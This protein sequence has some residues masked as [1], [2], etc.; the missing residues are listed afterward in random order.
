M[1]GEECLAWPGVSLS[2]HIRQDHSMLLPSWSD[3]SSLKAGDS[4]MDSRIDRFQASRCCTSYFTTAVICSMDGDAVILCLAGPGVGF[5]TC[6]FDVRGRITDEA[7]TSWLVLQ[8]LMRHNDF[9]FRLR[10][11]EAICPF[12]WFLSVCLSASRRESLEKVYAFNKNDKPQFNCNPSSWPKAKLMKKS[13]Y[14]PIHQKMF[15]YIFQAPLF[16]KIGRPGPWSQKHAVKPL[17]TCF[18]RWPTRGSK[19]RPVG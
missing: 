14:D 18:I 4:L 11:W 7:D 16:Q 6:S 5:L 8:V 17:S 15:L 2:R 13:L 10:S 9:C 12:I 3:S 19:K 1:T